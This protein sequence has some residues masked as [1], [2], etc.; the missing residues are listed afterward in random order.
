MKNFLIFLFLSICLF[1]CL[2]NQAKVD[3]PKAIQATFK[4]Q[5]PDAGKPMW[6]E[7]NGRYEATYKQ[8]NKDVS[9]S[10]NIDGTV[11]QTET[12]ISPEALPQGVRNYVMT[13]LEDKKITEAT[14]IVTTSGHTSY[15]AEVDRTDYLFDSNGQ[16]A[17][18]ETKEEREK[19]DSD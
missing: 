13:Q 4:K 3:V 5:Y 11:F 17:G 15:E 2:S 6:E 19:D 12:E 9:V 7:E 16:Y 14:R 10:Y 18:V 1:S 8:D